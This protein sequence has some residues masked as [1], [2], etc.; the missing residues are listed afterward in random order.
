M[1]VNVLSEYVPVNFMNAQY[2]QRPEEGI[3]SP[4]TGVT[5]GYET[6]CECKVSNLSP[7]E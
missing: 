2:T 1:H 4:R 5:D 6:L 7:L 3:R